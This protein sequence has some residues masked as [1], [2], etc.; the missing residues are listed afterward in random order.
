MES[1]CRKKA[2]PGRNSHGVLGYSA[3][4][5]Q[6]GLL[7]GP[8]GVRRVF[9]RALAGSA[10]VQF[11]QAESG[12]RRVLGGLVRGVSAAEPAP[13]RRR[14]GT[15]LRFGAVRGVRRLAGLRGPVSARAGPE[16]VGGNPA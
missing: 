1:V 7:L 3:L 2:E 9:R 16:A 6:S 13:R 15:L 11:H 8:Y 12:L 4:S 14:R 5:D 10:G